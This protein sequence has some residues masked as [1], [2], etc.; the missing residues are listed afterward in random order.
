M[1]KILFLISL[2]LEVTPSFAYSEATERYVSAVKK[3]NSTNQQLKIFSKRLSLDLENNQKISEIAFACAENIFKISPEK[4]PAHVLLIFNKIKNLPPEKR[5]QE[6][7][8]NMP[9]LV[10]L[11]KSTSLEVVYLSFLETIFNEAP[12]KISDFFALFIKNKQT[13]VFLDSFEKNENKFLLNQ[14]IKTQSIEFYCLST[15]FNG[16]TERCIALL[17]K[18]EPTL[19]QNWQKLAAINAYISE[20]QI[21][22]AKK[23][24]KEYIGENISCKELT[25]TPWINFLAAQIHRITKNYSQSIVCLELFKQSQTSDESA[26]FFYNLESAKSNY[27]NNIETASKHI[28]NCQEYINKNGLDNTFFSLILKI[29]NIKLLHVSKK[30]SE[31]KRLLNETIREFDKNELIPYKYTLNYYKKQTELTK[32]NSSEDKNCFKYFECADLH[33]TIF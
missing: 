32:S 18:I 33:N 30:K 24:L 14:K 21:M 5:T 10:D 1:L 4:Y 31:A 22:E 7:E 26:L 17:K 11:A 19:N 15:Q 25:E 8:K 3:I 27:K 9:S 2:F 23:I 16:R 12:E 20:N 6:I 13:H 28:L 29:E